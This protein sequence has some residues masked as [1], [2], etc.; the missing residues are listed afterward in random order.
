MAGIWMQ[1]CVISGKTETFLAY[2]QRANNNQLIQ[3]T[4]QYALPSMKI[5]HG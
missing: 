3:Q 4:M 5:W 2:K 1:A